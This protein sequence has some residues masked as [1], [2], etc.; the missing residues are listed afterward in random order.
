MGKWRSLLFEDFNDG[1]A[2]GWTLPVGCAGNGCPRVSEG[3]YFFPADWH[4]VRLAAVSNSGA[5]YES[6]QFSLVRADGFGYLCIRD[7]YSGTVNDIVCIQHLTDFHGTTVDKVTGSGGTKVDVPALALG[8]SNQWRIVRHIVESEC[9]I[10]LDG[11]LLG[12]VSC[13]NSLKKNYVLS[14][15]AGST[16]YCNSYID[17]FI[18]EARFK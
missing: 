3:Q 4:T 16:P 17:D 5:V 7:G 10:Y 14:M 13:F 12:T 11:D 9:E 15:V 8:G 18:M 1:V 2:N 6:I